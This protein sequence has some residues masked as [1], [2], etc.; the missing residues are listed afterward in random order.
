MRPE[1]ESIYRTAPIGLGVPDT[2][3]RFER[4]NERLAEM[5][6]LPVE[7]HIG[8]TVRELRPDLADAGLKAASGS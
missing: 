6:G 2:D 8:H 3:L 1:L 7:A 4:V 5:N